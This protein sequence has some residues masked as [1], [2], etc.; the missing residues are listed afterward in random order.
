[1]RDMLI[2]LS[3]MLLMMVTAATANA[4]DLEI[5]LRLIRGL[6]TGTEVEQA[7]GPSL[8]VDVAHRDGHWQRAWGLD[9]RQRRMRL[10][11]G[12]VA[13]AEIDDEKIALRI[14]LLERESD[15]RLPGGFDL[16]N[17][18]VRRIEVELD[19]TGDSL[20]G[21]YALTRYSRYANTRYIERPEQ[22]TVDALRA[23]AVDYSGQSGAPCLFVLVDRIEGGGK[24]VWNWNL[25]DDR[26]VDE[27]EIDGNTFTLPTGDG[28]LRGTLVTPEGVEITAG[29][30]EGGYPAI[31]ARGGDNFF[32]VA[33]ISGSDTDVPQVDVEGE[34]LDAQ[35][36]VGAQVVRFDGEKVTVTGAN[37]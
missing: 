19:R 27:V 15:G 35:V 34:S 12:R 7:D 9:T 31:Q 3:V 33:T 22:I 11:M 36:T 8:V 18:D 20:D 16:R 29:E 21:R 17:G 14:E 24:K 23:M 6:G 5:E 13:E 10:L 4:D 32:L 26:W 2:P 37:E 28:T 1:M 30:N 25:T